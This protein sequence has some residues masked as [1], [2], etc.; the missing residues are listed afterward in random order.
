M[1]PVN[2]QY[3]CHSTDHLNQRYF[4]RNGIQRKS[5]ACDENSSRLDKFRQNTQKVSKGPSHPQYPIITSTRNGYS[6]WPAYAT[7]QSRQ[8]PNRASILPPGVISSNGHDS[9]SIGRTIRRF[10]SVQLR[11]KPGMSSKG[12]LETNT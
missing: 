10:A 1:D 12:R 7:V 3:H 2:G 9:D 8:R 5:T 4:Q 11:S 6:P